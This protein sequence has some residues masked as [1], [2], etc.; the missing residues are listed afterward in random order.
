MKFANGTVIRRRIDDLWYI[1]RVIE[2]GD[3]E[4]TGNIG[5]IEY[6]DDKNVEENV[7]VEECDESSELLRGLSS[8]SIDVLKVIAPQ[9][10]L[11]ILLIG[12]MFF[13]LFIYFNIFVAK[14]KV[15]SDIHYVCVF[16]NYIYLE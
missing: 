12:S 5:K 13:L 14:K 6:L 15:L 11:I 8:T 2:R 10:L 16:S 1:V 7:P 3:P 9:D 4:S